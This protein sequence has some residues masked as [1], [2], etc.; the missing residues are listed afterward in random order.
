MPR[1]LRE[2]VTGWQF[3]SLMPDPMGRPAARGWRRRVASS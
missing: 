3:L 1:D 2:I